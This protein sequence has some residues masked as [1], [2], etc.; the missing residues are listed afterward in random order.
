MSDMMPKT[1]EEITPDWLNEVLDDS[2]TGGAQVSS[3]KKE[4]IGQ[5]AGFL[6]ELT[7]LT[8]TYDRE[9]PSAPA[10]II[11]KL[12]TQ[13]EAVRNLAQLINVYEREVRFF[14]QIADET[15]MRTPNCYFSHADA[16]KGEYVLL[17]EDLAPGRVGDQIATCSIEEAKTA[18]RALAGLHAA[19][20]DSPRLKEFA[21]MPGVDDQL[22]IGLIS[23]MYQQSWPTFVERY[24]DQVPAEILPIGE[25]FG[26]TFAEL[27]K[28]IERGP[29]TLTH[30]D[31]RLD[32]MFF[33]LADGSPI[34][35]IDWQLAQRGPALGD[36][37]YFLAGNLTT[38]ARRE[39][40]TELLHVYH[41]AL[42]ERGV[43]DYDYALCA[44]DYRKA[45]LPL[46]IFVVT[47]QEDFNI[48][49]YNERAQELMETMLD[50]YMTAIL[51][52]NAA[53][54]L[55]E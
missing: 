20:W 51:D 3:I 22:L 31:Y 21:W 46:F 5:G 11:A 4:I 40:E 38:E 30:S 39:H 41:E 50:R 53:E 44:E 33:D 42:V 36:V 25:K 27:A 18:L 10:S 13:D 35:I 37:T 23:M 8:L 7:R 55:L 24:G 54:F 28:E 6:G 19:W 48:E 17:L 49:D 2:V 14:E 15:P 9:A 29:L 16:A 34:A 26:Q 52:L 12:P 32:N 47:N 43:K 1:S 45:A